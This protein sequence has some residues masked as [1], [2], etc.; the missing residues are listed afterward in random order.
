MFCTH[1]IAIPKWKMKLRI[2]LKGRLN[3]LYKKKESDENGIKEEEENGLPNGEL[4][5]QK[6]GSQ[7]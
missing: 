7:L 4:K 2:H 5:P 6:K 1:P 3:F